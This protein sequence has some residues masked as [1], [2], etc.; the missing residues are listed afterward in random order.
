M[1]PTLPVLP[2]GLFGATGDVAFGGSGAGQGPWLSNGSPPPVGFDW[3]SAFRDAT[4]FA[5][6]GGLTPLSLVPPG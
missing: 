1:K 5:M 2:L 4:P 3:Q 6:P